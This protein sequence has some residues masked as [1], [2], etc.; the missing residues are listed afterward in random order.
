MPT[1]STIKLKRCFNYRGTFEQARDAVKNL[2]PSLAVGEPIV[3][4]YYSNPDKFVTNPSKEEGGPDKF[5]LA[6]GRILGVSVQSPIIVP[7]FDE[8]NEQLDSEGNISIKDVESKYEAAIEKYFNSETGQALLKKY[9]TND[10][11]QI[12][13]VVSNVDNVSDEIKQAFE[14]KT[15][16]SLSNDLVTQ[17]E[18]NEFILD[19]LHNSDAN[20]F[21][22]YV[23]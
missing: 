3:V 21:W 16:K 2:N 17:Q 22:D 14:E 4:G 15:G 6:I 19:N 9:M 20:I 1:T 12:V 11:S 8:N 7:L 5:F 10:A 23:N 13:N 18:L